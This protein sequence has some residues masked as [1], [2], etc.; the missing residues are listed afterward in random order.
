M[1]RTSNEKHLIENSK[2]LDFE[3]PEECKSAVASIFKNEVMDIPAS[4]I[5]IHG[6][7]EGKVYA[8]ID[9]AMGNIYHLKPSPEEL[10][11]QIR[12][13]ENLKPIKISICRNEKDGPAYEVVEGK[14]RYWAWIIAYGA[15]ASIPSLIVN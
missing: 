4:K 10:S 15:D 5:S 3:L 12:S 11:R 6:D 14:L 13:G 1:T 9:E 7:R 2:V 8:T